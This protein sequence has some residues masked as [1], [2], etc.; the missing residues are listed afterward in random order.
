M[1][2][3]LF[4]P[5]EPILIGLEN[6][7]STNICL[8]FFHTH[9]RLGNRQK[10]SLSL[11]FKRK[12]LFFLAKVVIDANIIF[13]KLVKISSVTTLFIFDFNIT[14]MCR[15]RI[16]PKTKF[17]KKAKWSYWNVDAKF[18]ILAVSRHPI[19]MTKNTIFMLFI[20]QI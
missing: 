3:L 20:K 13:G 18:W 5:V 7:N 16:R 8:H 11:M 12:L 19:W 17:K 15:N 6:F 9:S 4:F 1:N 10:C 14:L 2:S